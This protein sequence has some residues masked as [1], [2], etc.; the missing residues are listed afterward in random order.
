[1]IQF[2]AL[3]EQ[4]REKGEK[5]GWT[6]IEIPPQL[7]ASLKPGCKKSFRVKGKLDNY[8]F[9]GVALLPMGD[10]SFI[11]ALK[12]SIRKQLMKQKGDQLQVELEEDTKEK[13]ISAELLICLEDEPAALSYFNSLSVGH[14]R[15]F[16]TWI[17]SAKTD[18]TRIKRISQAV[19][20]L[21]IGLGYSEMVRM[22]RKNKL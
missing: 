21:S 5:S 22:N 14:Q 18:S 6:Y 17:E 8:V 16:S 4:F 20:A 9:E 15:Y 11:M 7:A 19:N 10:S 12:A 1:M 3:I 13:S 2:V